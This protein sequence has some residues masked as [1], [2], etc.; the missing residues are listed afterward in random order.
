MYAV[1]S[2]DSSVIMREIFIEIVSAPSGR[3][4]THRI[5]FNKQR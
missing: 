5:V 4:S 1:G 2:D 3:V